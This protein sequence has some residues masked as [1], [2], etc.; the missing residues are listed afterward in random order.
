[1]SMLAM[2][3][4]CAAQAVV[5]A[6]DLAGSQS[7]SCGSASMMEPLS[8]FTEA[9]TSRASD[10]LF[11]LGLLGDEATPAFGTR[12]SWRWHVGAGGAMD[13]KTSRNRLV[14]SGVG[15]SYFLVDDLSID[16]ELNLIYFSQR[17]D[18]A[19]GANFN[20]TLRYHFLTGDTWSVYADGGA[21]LLGTTDEVPAGGSNFNF[22]PHAGVGVSFDVGSNRRLMTGVR[23][24]HISN[25]N[26]HRDNPGRDSV[27]AYV[28]LSFPF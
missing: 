18:D 24:H 25:A 26:T 15:L 2:S 20:L 16:G 11:A 17:G 10:D 8:L 19:V 14:Q 28:S 6:D 12:G 27:Q 23:W 21:G 7:W 9:T 5:A 13:I 4:L 3:F 1:M 22:V